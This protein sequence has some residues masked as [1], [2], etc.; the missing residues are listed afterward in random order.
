MYS[1]FKRRWRKMKGFF[2]PEVF[3]KISVFRNF[4][5]FT[6]KHLCQR[7]EVCNFIKKE[8]PAQVFSYEFCE[9]FKNTYFYRAP[10]LA[11]SQLSQINPFQTMFHFSTLRKCQNTRGFLF[12]VFRGYRNRILA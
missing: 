12:D 1:F 2:R 9:I 10:M 7:P 5:K 11:A 8:T 3:C 6:G 4:A